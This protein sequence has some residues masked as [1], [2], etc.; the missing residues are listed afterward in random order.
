MFFSSCIQSKGRGLFTAGGVLAGIVYVALKLLMLFIQPRYMFSRVGVEF[1]ITVF[2]SI[3][4]I[5]CLLMLSY[6]QCSEVN[7]ARYELE[8]KNRKL[9]F[10]S[11]HDPMTKLMNRRSMEEVIARIEE[12]HCVEK[13]NAVAF[14]DVDNFKRFNDDYGHECGDI[15]LMKVAE[16]IREGVVSN[17]VITQ[18]DTFT[19]RW[20]GEEMIVLFH[21]CKAKQVVKVV[22]RIKDAIG[23]YRLPYGECE[24]KVTVTCGIAYD[25]GEARINQL[26]HRADSYMLDGKKNGK[27][28]IVTEPS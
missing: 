22:T 27:N 7:Q 26:I 9:M 8:E 1:S 2:N 5:F 19:C 24:L 10:M 23:A 12:E 11:S 17:N 3:M 4:C 28:C 21:D 20:G 15:V 25:S 6:M 16:I 14:F 13:Y 18:K